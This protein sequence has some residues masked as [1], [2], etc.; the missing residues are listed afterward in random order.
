MEPQEI[1]KELMKSE[2]LQSHFGISHEEASAASYT[3]TSD[4]TPIEIIKDVINCVA[5]RRTVQA[6][7]Q[8]ILKKISN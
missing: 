6:T 8:G 3:S 1:F 4:S 2:E 5:N 7:Y